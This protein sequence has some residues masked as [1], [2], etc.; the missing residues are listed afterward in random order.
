MI[1]TCKKEKIEMYE[2]FGF[3]DCEV[4]ESVWGGELWYEMRIVCHGKEE[5]CRER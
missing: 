4:G 5:C 1:L 2:K 3:T